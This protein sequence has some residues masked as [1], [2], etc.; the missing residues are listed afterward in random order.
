MW[1]WRESTHRR[2]VQEFH[3]LRLEGQPNSLDLYLVMACFQ[4]VLL[5]LVTDFDH[6]WRHL[7]F[8]TSKQLNDSL[9]IN[10]FMTFF[11]GSARYGRN[12]G[13]L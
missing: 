13:N 12:N 8:D 10:V 3:Q 9:S 4:T 5:L 2:I 1:I 7:C 11:V 6:S